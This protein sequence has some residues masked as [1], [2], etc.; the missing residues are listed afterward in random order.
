MRELVVKHVDKGKGIIQEIINC[1]NSDY[2]GSKKGRINHVDSVIDSFPP[3]YRFCPTDQELV[4]EYLRNKV[5]RERL[6]LNR[7]MDVDLYSCTPQQ[8]SGHL[9]LSLYL[10]I[11][12]YLSCFW[13]SLFLFFVE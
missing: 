4:A 6:P 9:S 3:G 1:T 12:L 7:I 2:V 5:G 11:F 10:Y 8:L 13:F